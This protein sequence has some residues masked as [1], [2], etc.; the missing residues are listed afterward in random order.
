MV[1][2]TMAWNV[3]E[4]L[5]TGAI[6]EEQFSLDVALGKQPVIWTKYVWGLQ[7]FHLFY[8]LYKNLHLTQNNPFVHL[9]LVTIKMD[10]KLSAPF[11]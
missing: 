6:N 3:L 1:L 2:P 7:Y 4:T 11:L 10:S 5:S 9:S 8:F